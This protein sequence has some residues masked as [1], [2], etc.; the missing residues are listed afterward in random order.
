MNE[1]VVSIICSSQ[2]D[3]IYGT[4]YA[5]IHVSGCRCACGAFSA[6]LFSAASSSCQCYYALCHY[7]CFFFVI[8]GYFLNIGSDCYLRICK[9][10]ANWTRT[11]SI[12]MKITMNAFRRSYSL[13]FCR[14]AAEETRNCPVDLCLIFVIRQFH[15]VFCLLLVVFFR[16]AI[17]ALHLQQTIFLFFFWILLFIFFYKLGH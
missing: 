8:I 9:I 16:N 13:F 10:E 14:W 2:P 4:L 11:C 5:P 7:H 17:I 1:M 12:K 15:I 6:Y 3:S